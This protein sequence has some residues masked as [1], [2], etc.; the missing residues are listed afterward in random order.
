V[1]IGRA[2]RMAR[3]H[4]MGHFGA[5]W[6]KHR[7]PIPDSAQYPT[8]NCTVRIRCSRHLTHGMG[9]GLQAVPG[10]CVLF[11]HQHM[12]HKMGRQHKRGA[13]RL[14]QTLRKAPAPRLWR[15]TWSPRRPWRAA[16]GASLTA[17]RS[18]LSQLLDI[19]RRSARA[20][21]PRQSAPVQRGKESVNGFSVW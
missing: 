12:Q 17:C 11:E 15:P 9:C 19:R 7:A 14:R 4:R 2:A 21:P 3:W 10:K 18:R 8:R 6:H 16:V 5:P 1:Y 13:R 20:A